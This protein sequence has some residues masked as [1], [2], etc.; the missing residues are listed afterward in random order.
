MHTVHNVPG[1][2]LACFSILKSTFILHY[3]TNYAM[4]TEVPRNTLKTVQAT[5][6]KTTMLEVM[7]MLN[8]EVTS[9]PAL[10]SDQH[11]ATQSAFAIE[12]NIA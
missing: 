10:L 12:E 6:K 5:K 4:Q 11:T 9:V 3:F 7:H 8:V 2:I 1:S